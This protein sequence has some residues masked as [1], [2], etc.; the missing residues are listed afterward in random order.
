MAGKNKMITT[1]K[2]GREKNI[3][4][5]KVDFRKVLSNLLE[6]GSKMSIE[7]IANIAQNNEIA[8]DEKIPVCQ[9]GKDMAAEVIDIVKKNG[10]IRAKKE[11]LP[12]QGKLFADWSKLLKKQHRTGGKS[13]QTSSVHQIGKWGQEMADLRRKQ[14]ILCQNLSPLVTTFMSKLAM[15]I[16]NEEIMVFYLQWLK[17]SL[18]HESRRCLPGLHRKYH[19]LWQEFKKAKDKGNTADFKL[20]QMKDDVDRAEVE[21]ADASFGLEHLLREIGQLYEAT[22]ESSDQ[23]EPKTKETISH[24]PDIAGRLLLWGH[25]LEVM[26]GDAS[27][28]PLTWVKAIIMSAKKLVGDKS[29]FVLSVLGIQSSGKSTLLNTMFGL[30]FAVS[31]GRCTRGIYIQLVEVD[32]SKSSLGFDYVLVVDTEGLRAPELGQQKH[33]HD[34]ELATLVIGLGDV[35]IMNIKGENMAEVKDVLQIAV[36]AFLRMKTVNRNIKIHQKCVFI[37]QN[38]PAV[39]AKERMLHG[40]Q[41]LQE[42]LDLMTVEAA[43]LENIADIQTF[44]Q[45]LDFDGKQHVW[46]FSNLW[47]GDPPMA[48]AN[49]GY[50]QKVSEVKSCLIEDIAANQN[51]YTKMSDLALRVED[52]WKG[53][54]ADDFVFSFRNSL[55]AKAY[56]SMESEFFRLTWDLEVSVMT[57][58]ETVAR[59]K[60]DNCETIDQLESCCMTLTNE[61]KQLV[62]K[63]TNN[64]REQLEEF[65]EKSN[66]KE[67]MIQWKAETINS[68]TSKGQECIHTG[69]DEVIKLKE[70]MR[71]DLM[72]NSKKESHEREIMKKAK[73]LADELK[74][75]PAT[76]Q[77]LHNKFNRMWLVWIHDLASKVSPEE[78]PIAE[79]VENV[80][81][82]RFTRDGAYLRPELNLHPLNKAP[83]LN[84]LEGSIGFQDIPQSFISIKTTMWQDFKSLF[85][86]KKEAQLQFRCKAIAIANSICQQIDVHL[87]DLKKQDTKFKQAHITDIV[88]KVASLI[89]HHNAQ[90]S[91]EYMFTLLPNFKVRVTVL[92]CCHAV[93]VFQKMQ[94]EYEQKHG[95]VAKLESYKN[96]A[97]N[98]FKNMVKQSTDEVIAADL[99]CDTLEEI[100]KKTVNVA[101]PLDVVKNTLEHFAYTKFHL[102]LDILDDLA[103]KGQFEH[104]K[105]YITD[106][107]TYAHKWV[108][109][110]A[111][112]KFFN[113]NQINQGHTEYA[114]LAVI[115]LRRLFKAVDVGVRKGTECARKERRRRIQ[116]WVS[117]FC[118][119]V[120]DDLAV[121]ESNM[122]Q[123]VEQ[124]VS[125]FVNFE[126]LIFERLPILED[127]ITQGFQNE[128]ASSIKWEGT[129]PYQQVMDRLWGCVEQCPF[130]LEP[131]QYTDIQ[132]VT[133]GK[134]HQCVQ[135]RPGG[136]GGDRWDE[137][138]RKDKLVVES[139]NYTVQWKGLYF[140]CRDCHFECR[141]SG[142][143]NMTGSDWQRHTAI[144]YKTYLPHWDI[145]PNSSMDS[146]EYWMWFMTT[147]K[148]QLKDMY[149]AQLPDIPDSWNNITKE[150]ALT[151]LRRADS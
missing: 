87:E 84:C 5:M 92:I 56:N 85:S 138:W 15:S 75:K 23:L 42:D 41:K 38:V 146:S 30:Q 99:F 51:S 128:T 139:C 43:N 130:C 77:D 122:K 71:I 24:L 116:V 93:A 118:E 126:R 13:K 95:S 54:L 39:N 25:P 44:N 69:R 125:D 134:S 53:V 135:H 82:N 26:D 140:N 81:L 2:E 8:V 124:N 109:S 149:N 66:L 49:P 48:A 58:V 67:I 21:L 59:N 96:R 55:A 80:L 98:L 73:E 136:V 148:H 83:R 9:Q 16:S 17:L 31:A 94:D 112:E 108:T 90:N 103:R 143:C 70:A 52:L 32:K 86:S 111:N 6:T 104:F 64:L 68:L 137:S 20:Q 144:E 102:I 115:R 37:H 132:H 63:K 72:Q 3:N 133:K 145:Q 29:I 57:W 40:L 147:Y 18:D 97:W 46:Y 120:K 131:C 113:D 65:F 28:V 101:L 11:M 7:G 10:V 12:I 36:H 60:L 106:A 142:N 47:N 91:K 129:T 62:S 88:S 33:D 34:N 79:K 151:S 74:G 117:K 35:T 105:Q 22:M 127:K 14:V 50:S 27:N 45:V 100:I 61:L 141:K 4:D 110:W 119:S 150:K 107:K 76:D 1:F 123:V 114:N 78:I 89:D 121:L 19:G